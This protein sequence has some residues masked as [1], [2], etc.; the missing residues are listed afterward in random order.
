MDS[1]LRFL[2]ELKSRTGK[3]ADKEFEI[4]EFRFENSSPPT[5]S[6]GNLAPLYNAEIAAL[7]DIR[8]APRGQ[9]G[10]GDL[11]RY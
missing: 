7:G 4:S 9:A 5:E 10:D 11:I 1:R 2:K 8:Y 3:R 6:Q